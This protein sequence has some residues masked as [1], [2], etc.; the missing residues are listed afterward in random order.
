VFAFEVL[1]SHE[2][3]G[4]VYGVCVDEGRELYKILFE[5]QIV[6]LIPMMFSSFFLIEIAL[7]TKYK[8]DPT[9]LTAI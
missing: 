3:K 7:D 8:A 4:P 9:H 2:V 5:D 1:V 6:K